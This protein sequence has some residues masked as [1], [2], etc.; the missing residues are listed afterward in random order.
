MV[1]ADGFS[2]VSSMCRAQDHGR[3]QTKRVDI[4]ASYHNSTLQEPI[5]HGA[6]GI[7]ILAVEGDGCT[8]TADIGNV[9]MIAR[10]IT[11]LDLQEG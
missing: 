1:R 6:C 8:D 10:S 3:P 9:T 7:S 5:L 4:D 11:Q 2:E